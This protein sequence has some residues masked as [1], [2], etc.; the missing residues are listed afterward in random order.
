MLH[1]LIDTI[2]DAYIY[3]YGSINVYRQLFVHV[4]N[5]NGKGLKY[6]RQKYLRKKLTLIKVLIHYNAMTVHMIT[7]LVI[8]IVGKSKR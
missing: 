1:I 6:F 3:I 4:T 5:G 7:M 8:L 2:I